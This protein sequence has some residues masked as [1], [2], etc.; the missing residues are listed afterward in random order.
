[1]VAMSEDVGGR[2]GPRKVWVVRAGVGAVYSNVFL[3]QGLV[4]MGFGAVESVE[5]LTW[6]AVTAL[7]HA[8]MPEE[9]SVT[10]GLAAGALYRLA[11]DMAVGDI[12]L[13]PEGGG[14][15]L[16]GEVIGDYRFQTEPIAEDY[17]H[18][19]PVRWFARLGPNDIPDEAKASLG[20]IMTFF[21][22]A[23]QD[24]LLGVI[25]PLLD[26][27]APPASVIQTP[28]I[29]TKGAALVVL[30][31]ALPDLPETEF[32][33][34][35]ADKVDLRY[36]LDQIHNRDLALPDFQRSFVW[37]P[38]NTRE[39]IVSISR[40]FP[41][42]NL[43]FLRG[44]SKV[45]LPRA[46]E[47]APDLDGHVPSTLV[48][49]GQ[50]RLS[51]LYQA[52]FGRGSHRFFVDIGALLRGE[53]IDAAVSYLATARA[54]AFDTVEAQAR[55]LMFPLSRVGDYTSWKDEVIDQRQDLEADDL[56][57][58]RGFLNKVEASVISPMRGYQ[59]PV[60]TLTQTTSAEAVCT[61]FETLNRTGIKLSVFELICARAFAQGHRLREDWKQAQTQH[62]VFEDF[63]LDPYYILQ[64]IA[65]RIGKK[66]QRG[67]VVGLDV[68]DIVENWW[69]TVHGMERGL[70]MLR[71]ECGVLTK[72]W[73]PYATM[74]PALAAAWRDVDEA[75]GA[76]VGARRLKLQRWFWCTC[77]RG[78]YENAPN[79]RA[80][81]DVPALHK[82][83]TDGDAPVGVRE[84]DFQASAWLSTTP[85]QRGMYRST[86]ALLM[87][88]HP[89]DF[90]QAVPL[91]K[92][93]IEG[94]AVD[95][96][97]IFPTGYLAETSWN[98]Q[99]DTVLNHTLIDK[100]TNI[101]I[102][103]RPPSA[104]LSDM[105]G[106][107]SAA[108]V[109]VLQSHGL[110][111]AEDGSL[112]LDNYPGFL[113]W[114]QEY[115]A[116][117]LGA[118][119]TGTPIG[120]DTGAVSAA[121]LIS[122]GES[123][124]VEFKTSARWNIH[125]QARDERLEQRIVETVAGFMNSEGGTL[126]IGVDDDGRPVGLDE[127]LKLMQ[128]P[129]HDRYQLW[130]TDLIANQLGKPAA[131]AANVTFDEVDG[132]D[133]CMVVARAAPAPVFVRPP[134]STADEFHL[135]VQNS[136]RQLTFQEYEA[137]RAQRWGQ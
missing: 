122:A 36:M 109:A 71:D 85:R 41:A 16:A 7:V 123:S 81:A 91:T 96:H 9:P 106:E 37:D 2:E 22:P 65:L 35:G 53:D 50:Q 117:E 13:T 1:M 60:T 137:Y 51:S 8:A 83:L 27:A 61:I 80:E 23:H 44:G 89:L 112:W 107:L 25:E 14:S 134:K 30:P 111:A 15:R 116:A 62:P 38:A 55:T 92:S 11:N 127:D 58:L 129:D 20:S 77:F 73:L 101:S 95:D 70:I 88:R 100:L 49:D 64:A 128:K 75:T 39:L 21:G 126:L 87:R 105:K 98:N 72:K 121:Q 130:L 18:T 90:H 82:W 79:S 103:K 4:A 94:T 46:A 97:H 136:T 10:V 66:P 40:G 34:F 17:R 12:V 52:F 78:D 110:P 102:G 31:E 5:G 119:V 104:Y 19:R 69:P 84:F 132:E 24:Q 45:F 114:R 57:R 63:E 86:I 43:L 56:K 99:A 47:E 76:A 131:A 108:L 54:K 48:L 32:S 135:R 133:V 59:F 125:T 3:A 120:D 74:L 42:G 67:I 124:A 29:V 33:H 6:E 26:G 28:T 118:A 115:L 113:E 68:A 93:V